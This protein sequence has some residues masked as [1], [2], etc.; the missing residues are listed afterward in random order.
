M[1]SQS[2]SRIY[3]F[4]TSSEMV[5]IVQSIS[6]SRPGQRFIYGNHNIHDSAF[7]DVTQTTISISNHL[8]Y[9]HG[10]RIHAYE[11][12]I[13]S[14]KKQFYTNIL[15]HLVFTA[16]NSYTLP[17]RNGYPMITILFTPSKNI[18]HISNL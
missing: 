3:N 1:T 17:K 10:N 7:L 2:T 4:T 6:T 12:Y 8:R 5:N 14:F 9:H 15:A 11:N 13:L 16:K 18:T